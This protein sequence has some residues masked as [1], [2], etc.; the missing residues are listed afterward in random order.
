MW[1]GRTTVA[2]GIT[3]KIRWCGYNTALR[4]ALCDSATAIIVI[5]SLAMARRGVLHLDFSRS[6][7]FHS[8]SFHFW[9]KIS[10]LLWMQ[11][12]SAFMFAHLSECGLRKP[13][14]R[15]IRSE[16]R[17]RQIIPSDQLV[18]IVDNIGLPVSGTNRALSQ[19]RWCSAGPEDGDILIALNENH[20]P[21]ADFVKVLRLRLPQSFPGS[22]FSF[23]PADI[24]SQILNFGS[25]APIDVQVTAPD[26][27]KRR[28]ICY[29]THATHKENTWCRRREARAILSLS[30]IQH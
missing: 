21:T 17:I 19:Y 22:T 20:A 28:G 25:P 16:S 27:A 3:R 18:S 11:A 30:G 2:K 24:V 9:E 29:L 8:A 7:C 4:Y 12:R 6:F 15:S 1:L 13:Q 14:L 26:K 10:F 23:L 5:S